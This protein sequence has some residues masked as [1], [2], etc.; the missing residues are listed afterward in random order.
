MRLA[1]RG[2]EFGGEERSPFPLTKTRE[3]A[4]SALA[5]TLPNVRLS[6]ITS[7]PSL[8]FLRFRHLIDIS[9]LPAGPSFP[10]HTPP[11]EACPAPAGLGVF[12]PSKSMQTAPT[13]MSV[14]TVA[15]V[16]GER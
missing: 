1:Q 11:G 13:A 7:P 2:G 4:L 5:I 12:T 6:S 14:E 8:P 10:Y 3:P 15:E 9:L 16:E